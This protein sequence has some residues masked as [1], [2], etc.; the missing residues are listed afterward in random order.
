MGKNHVRSLSEMPEVNLVALADANA[1]LAGQLAK[2]YNC[3]GYTDYLEMIERE[4]IACV[5]VCVPTSMHL[6]VASACMRKG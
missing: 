1:T 4:D 3:Q 6:E 5:S 2:Q